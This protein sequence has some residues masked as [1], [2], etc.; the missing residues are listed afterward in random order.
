MLPVLVRGRKVVVDDA[1]LV[2]KREEIL[3]L[4]SYR[5]ESREWNLLV[6]ERAADLR[7]VHG[8]GCV[9]IEDLPKAQRLA[10]RINR[11]R[12]GDGIHNRGAENAAGTRDISKATGCGKIASPVGSRRHRLNAVGSCPGLPELLEIEEEEGLVVA[13]VDFRNRD[14]PAYR[15]SIIVAAHGV[16]DVLARFIRALRAG[17][18]E[19]QA[20]VQGFVHEIVVGAAVQLIG[21][22]LHGVVDCAAANLAVLRGKITG[23]DIYLLDGIHARRPD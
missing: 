9:G 4:G 7:S 10:G 19:R 1:G 8:P 6:G 22:R 18:G 3:N 5:I 2:R 21:A 15:E 11:R 17:I 13:V 20:G 23:L 14:R 12:A 16:A